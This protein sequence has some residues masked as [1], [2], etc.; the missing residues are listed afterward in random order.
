MLTLRPSASLNVFNNHCVKNVQI[1]GLN[2]EKYEP[3]KTPYM[4]TFHVV[5]FE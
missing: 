4:D 1:F 5:N 3:E 2:T